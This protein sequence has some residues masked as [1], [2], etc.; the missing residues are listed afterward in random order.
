MYPLD[1]NARPAEGGGEMLTD[2]RRHGIVGG[3]R[4]RLIEFPAVDMPVLL[5]VNVCCPEGY[6][7]TMIKLPYGNRPALI[8]N[9]SIWGHEEDAIISPTRDVK[10]TAPPKGAA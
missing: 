5:N 9:C 2:I 4:Y 7:G 8:A 10:V 1:A 3:L 6:K